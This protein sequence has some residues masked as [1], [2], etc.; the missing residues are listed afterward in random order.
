MGADLAQKFVDGFFANPACVAKYEAMRDTSTIQQIVDAIF[1]ELIA[2]S[3]SPLETW[4]LGFVQ[5]Y[6]DQLLEQ[7]FPT[8]TPTP[9]APSN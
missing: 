3:V 4:V 2:T 6:V 8:P 5:G 7:W 9:P 1:A